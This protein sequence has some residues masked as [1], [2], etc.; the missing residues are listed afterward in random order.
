[1]QQ[2]ICGESGVKEKRLADILY[3]F[4]QSLTSIAPR[5]ARYLELIFRTGNK[6]SGKPLF[7]RGIYFTSSMR[8]GSALDAEL[9]ET[10]GVPA[11]S[12][13]DGRV[14]EHDR[15][16][17]L[18]D[19]LLKKVFPEQGLV[20]NAKD[21]KKQHF[22]R[23]TTILGTI[24]ASLILLIIYTFL[25]SN[26]YE[27][28]I[29]T[30]SDCLDR[31]IEDQKKDPNESE[32]LV[33]QCDSNHPNNYRIA[34]DAAEE[35]LSGKLANAIE[36][37]KGQWMFVPINWFKNITDKQ[38]RDAAAIIYNTTVLE[39]FLRATCNVMT[40][41]TATKEDNWSHK[42][43][44]ND[45]AELRALHR[46]IRIKADKPL[47]EA[48][49]SN[50][51]DDLFNYI[52]QY[53]TTIDEVMSREFYAKH[54]SELH[55][56]LTLKLEHE[57]FNADWRP[58]L[59]ME[60]DPN[61]LDK[62][63]ENG[64]GLFNEYWQ[65]SVAVQ[66]IKDLKD[67]IE[68]FNDTETQ[69]LGLIRGPDYAESR[70]LTGV[71]RLQYFPDKWTD[72]FEKLKKARETI[73]GHPAY[74]NDSSSLVVLCEETLQ[75]VNGSYK[76]LLN[77]LDL[78]SVKEDKFLD[79]IHEKLED[80]LGK[81]TKELEGCREYLDQLENKFWASFN[82][83]RLCEIRFDMYS[84]VN[85][86]IN[87]DRKSDFDAI[88]KIEN[89]DKEARNALGK[90]PKGSVPASLSEAS[91]L[92]TSIL[93]LDKQ[94]R[95]L[96]VLQAAPND[97]ERIKE[98]VE[99]NSDWDWTR[100]TNVEANKKFDPNGAANVINSWKYLV[101]EIDSKF[102]EKTYD[103][104]N[105]AFAEYS[106]D[107]LN[108][109]LHTV[110]LEW[111][112]SNIPNEKTWKDQSEKLSKLDLRNVFISLEKFGT[113]VEEALVIIDDKISKNEERKNFNKN[114]KDITSSYKDDC[115]NMLDKWAKLSDNVFV[116]RRTLLEQ[117]PRD[118]ISQYFPSSGTYRPKSPSEFVYMY[119]TSL[120]L[121]SLKKLA[122]DTVATSKQH[123]EDLK[124]YEDK[125]P[126]QWDGNDLNP[127]DVK[128]AYS[129]L[130][131]IPL[132]ENYGEGTIGRGAE[133]NYAELNN[134]LE[135]LSKPSVPNK[136]KIERIRQVLQGLPKDRNPYYCKISFVAP[137][138]VEFTRRFEIEQN[139]VKSGRKGIDTA[140]SDEKV[141]TVEYGTYKPIYI[142]FY[143]FED[144]NDVVRLNSFPGQ[145]G[146]FEGRWAILRILHDYP[147]PGRDIEGYIRLPF[148]DRNV[149]ENSI[150]T[151]EIRL[152]L[153]FFHDEECEKPITGFVHA[154]VPKD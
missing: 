15:A 121:N 12:L 129:L 78:N 104:K 140:I 79:G 70:R 119:W 95:L 35:N 71:E 123:I 67:A 94:L 147:D 51:I 47:S 98:L 116:A 40:V 2:I 130:E 32:L 1:M 16:Y 134:L 101:G 114:L 149:K 54:K 56:P 19:L 143:Q 22:L 124:R 82:G 8:E 151:R 118:L 112:N 88:R 107:Y 26:S 42:D 61:S 39:P 74:S 139:G 33:V 126:L 85:E 63:I 68:E 46:L 41:H 86:R 113:R 45:P 105:N 97:L 11:E 106:E 148:K 4:P 30:L 62:A 38:L 150:V 9:A 73:T 142:K 69:M 92:C 145:I 17:F 125:F 18:R 58:A 99:R 50:F 120:T 154:I 3:T 55:E 48:E 64:I 87:A 90:Y 5:L 23:K 10:L 117:T 60:D 136:K 141:C 77:E 131:E 115:Q 108:Y 43:G 137:S 132:R 59:I 27:N 100:I 153:D 91:E 37:F 128:E 29:G 65:K 96:S 25:A 7:F 14:W 138:P 20:T 81:I 44:P 80:S 109:W 6:W 52:K 53:G 34:E 72:S 24:A 144:S 31:F 28:R 133:T 36:N 103:D 122:D 111:I 57:I 49:R 146:P 21:A 152:K 93:D 13:P 102:K 66:G 76:F 75:D 89:A 83:R 135:G 84:K 127:E 110:P